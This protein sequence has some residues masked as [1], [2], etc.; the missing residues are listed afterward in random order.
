MLQL[1]PPPLASLRGTLIAQ[2][3]KFNWRLMLEFYVV[4]PRTRG[5]DRPAIVLCFPRFPRQNRLFKI[6]SHGLSADSPAL[7]RLDP[8][9]DPLRNDPRI[10][11][12]CE[13]KQ[14]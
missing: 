13:E 2:H 7:L 6:Y 5:S 12:L 3:L 10:Q 1:S 4:K 14:H 9:F 11:K 8:M